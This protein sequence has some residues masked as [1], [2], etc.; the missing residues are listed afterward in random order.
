MRKVTAVRLGVIAA[1]G[2]MGAAGAVGAGCSSSNPSGPTGTTDSGTTTADSGP[3]VDTGTIGNDSGP[4]SEGGPV[5]SGQPPAPAS[6][7]L[8]HT[9]PG[10]PPF[11]VCFATSSAGAAASVT[12]L[13]ALP[14]FPVPL[15]FTGAPGTGTPTFP[16]VAVGTP[17]I[18]PGMIFAFPNLGLSFENLT[19]TPFAVLA[20]AIANDV[21]YDAGNGVNLS[22]GGAEE[23]CVHLIGTHGLGTGEVAPATPGRLTLGTDFFPLPVIASGTLKN[24]NTY[25]LTVNGCLPNGTFL[26][27]DAPGEPTITCGGGDAGPWI[28]IAQMDTTTTPADGG[29][30][31][32]FANRSTALENTPI[33]PTGAPA[34]LHTQAADGIWPVFLTPTE[35]DAGEDAGEMLA[36]VPTMLT[37]QPVSYSGPAGTIAQGGD[38]ITPVVSVPTSVTGNPNGVFAVLVQPLD[39]GQPNNLQWPGS[40]SQTTGAPIPGDVI[41]YPLTVVQQLSAV[42]SS[43]N[44]DAAAGYVPGTNYTFVFMGDPAAAQLPNPDGG[45]GLN[46]LYDGRGLHVVAFPSKFVSTA[47]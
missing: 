16:P 5:D 10:V 2:V 41:G 45:A 32:Q 36:Y 30:G 46:P 43:T 1:F 35:Y 47:P 12:P 44:A 23:D 24:T 25:L 29:V 15:G 11:R 17:G 33:V 27:S 18:Y 40:Y 26:P 31:V 7:V 22:D 3:T 28:G 21:N 42:S 34:E 37:Q 9:G 6:L 38:T 20:S 19:I 4:P 13:A 39:G 14:D 8:A